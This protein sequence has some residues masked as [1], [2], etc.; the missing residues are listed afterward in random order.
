LT[1]THKSSHPSPD[2]QKAKKAAS[3]LCEDSD[4]PADALDTYA[5]WLSPN[6]HR[7][8]NN[9][10]DNR[11]L[12]LL[13]EAKPLCV[14]LADNVAK[15]VGYRCFSLSVLW[16][17]DAQ[18]A[19]INQQLRQKKGPTNIL[20]FPATEEGENS[21]QDGA[22]FLG[23]M[24][25]GFDTL[26]REAEESQR[27]A[28]HHLAHLFVHGLLHLAGYDHQEDTEAEEMEALEIAFLADLELPNPY[29]DI[30]KEKGQARNNV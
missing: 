16:T 27:P 26:I 11:W 28:S 7:I 14:E 12:S 3:E 19:E 13:E 6:A 22:I 10:A 24:A 1:I 20:S 17:D 25:L 23:D 9:I 5:Y 8:E 29:L 15:L 30:A 21:E 18:M 2:A 4:S